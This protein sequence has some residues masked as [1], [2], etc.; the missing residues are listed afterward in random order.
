MLVNMRKILSDAEKNG[1]AVGCINTPDESMIQGVIAAAEELQTPLIIDHAEVHD[2]FMPIERIGPPM[3]EAAKNASVPICVHLDHGASYSFVMRA[4]RVGFTSIMYDLSACSFEENKTKLREFTKIAH[5]L[6]I[7]VEGE[8][9]VMHS[10]KGDTHGGEATDDISSSYTDPDMAAEF[11]YETNVDALAVCFGTLHGVYDREPKLNLELLKTI[12][13]KIDGKTHLVMHG[14]SGLDDNQI[15]SAID[16][17]I[18]KINYYTY[19]SRAVTPKLVP[20][21]EAQGG[22][23]YYHDVL[24]EGEKIVK[25]ITADVLRVF[26]NGKT[27]VC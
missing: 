13:E 20:W 7:T 1:Y 9:G 26:L 15:R 19:M 12:H 4:L 22:A 18:S 27:P 14:A 21:I 2:S 10:G 11:A 25:D 6:D 5:D 16:C 8:L 24:I 23:P 17:G 3:I